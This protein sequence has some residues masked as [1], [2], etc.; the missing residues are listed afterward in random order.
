MHREPEGAVLGAQ[1]FMGSSAGDEKIIAGVL[2]D[3][4]AAHFK[5]CTTFKKHDPL[6]VILSIFLL[7]GYRRADYPLDAD[8]LT[9]KEFLEALSCRGDIISGEDVGHIFLGDGSQ[10]REHVPEK[11]SVGMTP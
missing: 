1:N 4:C 6:I 9:A 11:W 10:S 3:L 7:I 8:V 5:C 2:F